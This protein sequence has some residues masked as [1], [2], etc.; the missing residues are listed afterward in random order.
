MR[1]HHYCAASARSTNKATSSARRSRPNRPTICTP[2]GSPCGS[3]IPGTLTHGVPISVHNRLKLGDPVDSRSLRRSARRGRSEQCIRIGG[4]IG[5]CL[6]SAFAGAA[7]GIVGV[8]GDAFGLFEQ[9]AQA[10]PNPIAIVVVL[11]GERAVGLVVLN[12]EMSAE[13]VLEDRRQHQFVHVG[14]G[15]F[16]C[17]GGGLDRRLHRLARLAP[18]VG[19]DQ[20]DARRRRRTLIDAQIAPG[21]GRGGKCDVGDIRPQKLPGVSRCQEKHFMPTVGSSL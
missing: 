19:A 11:E 13:G 15:R 18:V 10:G 3:L 4:K 12:D 5:Q 17:L 9:V 21:D 2:S 20:S 1:S 7:C 8:G 16:G 6:A 14:A